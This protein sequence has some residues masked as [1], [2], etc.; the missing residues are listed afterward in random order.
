ML[1]IAP[2]SVLG[3]VP[4]HQVKNPADL[5]T[6]EVPLAAELWQPD[7]SRQLPES[8]RGHA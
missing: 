4:F 5:F 6:G 3:D 2:T 8:E 7:P 1:A